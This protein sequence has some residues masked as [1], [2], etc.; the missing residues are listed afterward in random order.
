[1]SSIRSEEDMFASPVASSQPSDESVNAIR[2]SGNFRDQIQRLIETSSCSDS[3]ESDL[4]S[5]NDNSELEESR[6][7]ISKSSAIKNVETNSDANDS[8]QTDENSQSGELENKSDDDR[9]LDGD[10]SR[11]KEDTMDIETNSDK[12]DSNEENRQQNDDAIELEQKSDANSEFDSEGSGSKEDAKDIEMKNNE[13]HLEQNDEN[14]QLGGDENNLEEH[15]D[16]S[17]E[18]DISQ[19]F[20]N[21]GERMRQSHDNP[22]SSLDENDASSK[23]IRDEIIAILG[24]K[25]NKRRNNIGKYTNDE[26]SESDSGEKGPQTK[27]K[28]RQTHGKNRR[29][30]EG[31]NPDTES[32]ATNANSAGSDENTSD[33]EENKQTRTEGQNS[34]SG[35]SSSFSIRRRAR[36]RQNISRES[37]TGR[38]TS[39]EELLEEPIR[40]LLSGKQGTTR[41]PTRRIQRKVKNRPNETDWQMRFNRYCEEE[42]RKLEEVNRFAVKVELSLDRFAGDDIAFRE[43]YSNF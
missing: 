30:K 29:S 21:Q 41:N 1:M 39:E 7:N 8:E 3:E 32:N 36:P 34:G 42:T 33:I 5:K 26:T 31:H 9:E 37:Y 12:T 25:H 40:R 35:S 19:I 16:D 22:S 27:R 43:G 23:S 24:G 2:T 4:E 17:S 11:S 38:Q 10:G 6:G 15:T 20:P 18:L 28:S 14:S 13:A